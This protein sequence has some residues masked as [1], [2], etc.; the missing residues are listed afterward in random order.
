MI[1][2]VGHKYTSPTNF[3]SQS[4]EYKYKQPFQHNNV[5][6]GVKELPDVVDGFISGMPHGIESWAVKVII[7]SL[8]IPESM[9]LKTTK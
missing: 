4:T 1:N 9:K 3:T 2:Q 7:K 6:F 5:R 8:Y